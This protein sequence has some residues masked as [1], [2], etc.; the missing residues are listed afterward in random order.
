MELRGVPGIAN[1][2]LLRSKEGS[3]RT[4][5]SCLPFLA[6]VSID[7]RAG[8]RTDDA[9]ASITVAGLCRSCTGFATRRRVRLVDAA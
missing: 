7:R 2:S 4:V 5:A 6:K 8:D 1:P 9:R 3:S